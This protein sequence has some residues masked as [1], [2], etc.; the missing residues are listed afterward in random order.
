M[1]NAFANLMFQVWLDAFL[2]FRGFR[3]SSKR[4]VGFRSCC[5]CCGVLEVRNEMTKTSVDTA[6]EK[7]S[8]CLGVFSRKARTN[9]LFRPVPSV[10]FHNW[11]SDEVPCLVAYR[12]RPHAVDVVK[13]S[14]LWAETCAQKQTRHT[15]VGGGFVHRIP[16]QIGACFTRIVHHSLFL[17]RWLEA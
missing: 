1:W 12:M 6:I 8:K 14:V 2:P 17:C 13:K 3:P 4:V 16:V 9:Y 10:L 15:G 7:H 11:T 5:R